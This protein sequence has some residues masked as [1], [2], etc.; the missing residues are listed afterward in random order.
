MAKVRAA[1]KKI[2]HPTKLLSKSEWGTSCKQ[3]ASAIVFGLGTCFQQL[4]KSSE[5]YSAAVCV[6]CNAHKRTQLHL[7]LREG[8]CPSVSGSGC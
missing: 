2:A 6:L 5:I 3:Y 8:L 4:S 1:W 7:S